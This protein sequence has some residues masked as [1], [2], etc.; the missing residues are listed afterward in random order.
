MVTVTV[1]I[2]AIL[3]IQHIILT[4]IMYKMPLDSSNPLRNM[5]QMTEILNKKLILNLMKLS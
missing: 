4:L 3:L 1:I 2:M 5:S